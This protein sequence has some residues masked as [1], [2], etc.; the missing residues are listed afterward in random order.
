MRICERQEPR[1]EAECVK[2]KILS[3]TS[4]KIGQTRK[5]AKCSPTKGINLVS[6]LLHSPA[7]IYTRY[8][9]ICLARITSLCHL[10]MWAVIRWMLRVCLGCPC[11]L[12]VETEQNH[13]PAFLIV[14]FQNRFTVWNE[15]A[16][17]NNWTSQEH[18]W[19]RHGE[20][21]SGLWMHGPRIFFA[22]P[23]WN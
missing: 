8:A 13:S 12:I 1:W 15:S 19:G 5:R 21:P 23:R 16:G 18:D 11:V 3:K 6:P 17:I 4:M 20:R 14:S 9:R 10:H 22:F 2:G 7:N